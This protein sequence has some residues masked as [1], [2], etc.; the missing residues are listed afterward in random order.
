LANSLV[1]I[2]EIKNLTALYSSW[3]DPLY[4]QDA[5]DAVHSG[6]R[7]LMTIHTAVLQIFSE[8]GNSDPMDLC[9]RCVRVLGLPPFAA[10]PLVLHSFLAHK[11]AAARISLN[12]IFAPFMES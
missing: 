4:G 10:N 2:A 8:S 11:E 12:S 3:G 5:V 9:R 1:R 6:M 7:Y